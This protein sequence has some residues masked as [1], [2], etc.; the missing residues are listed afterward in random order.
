[1]EESVLFLAVCSTSQAVLFSGCF[2]RVG[3]LSD[4]STPTC[5]VPRSQL[6][7][8]VQLFVERMRAT[9]D[10]LSAKEHLGIRESFTQ[11]VSV[12][13]NQVLMNTYLVGEGQKL[14]FQG[15]GRLHCKDGRG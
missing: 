9:Q 6:I 4:L 10:L 5:V 3:T 11:E 7:V 12:K 14:V 1:M 8:D 13:R 2:V 15:E